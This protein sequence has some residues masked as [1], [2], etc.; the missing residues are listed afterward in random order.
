MCSSF[1]RVAPGESAIV[2]AFQQ[3]LDQSVPLFFGEVVSS[4]LWGSTSGAGH[5]KHMKESS[6]TGD[7]REIDVLAGSC[8]GAER[9]VPSTSQEKGNFLGVIVR[10]SRIL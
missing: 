5:L 1:L 2:A 3:M 7:S 10:F 4:C 8:G 6:S 9:V